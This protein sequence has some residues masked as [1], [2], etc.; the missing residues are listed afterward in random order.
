M[1]DVLTQ[2]LD[3]RLADPDGSG[4]LAVPVRRVAIGRGLAAQAAALLAPLELGPRLAVVHDPDTRLAMGDAVLAA[5]RSALGDASVVDVTLERAPH[6]D[7]ATVDVVIAR[8]TG[9][10]ALVAVG[11]G[12]VNDLVKHAA[13]RTGRPW[14][15]FGTA[16]SM[17]GYTSVSAAITEHGHKKSLPAV[18]ARG[19][20]L[21]LDVLAAAPRHMIAAGL[22]DSICRPTAQF[23]WWLSHRLLDTPYRRVPFDLLA[24]D[25]D[26]LLDSAAGLVRGDIAAL[27]RL[28][29][30]LVLS[31]LGMTL[32]GGSWPASQGEH[33]VSHLLEMRP[34]PT[35]PPALH[36][37][38]IAVTT[39]TLARLQAA[40]VAQAAP[41]F[42]PPVLSRE[43][44]HARF[45]ADLGASCWVASAAKRF[46]AAQVAAIDTRLRAVWPE[47]RTQLGAMSR[48]VEQI[49]AA[50]AAA[51]A[52][53]T[54]ARLGIAETDYAAAVRDA[55]LIRDRFTV[56]DVLAD[57]S[58]AW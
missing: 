57:A 37:E 15:V 41:R 11:S 48:P 1:S 5:L 25:E 33:L 8:S 32:V 3:G 10:D 29:R 26:A 24:H 19:V 51:G 12:T 9:A 46:D 18:A 43:D 38:Q 58:G 16:P 45:G 7:T 23:D 54:P 42:A 21:D 6:P 53:R 47:L 4:V 14:V 56:L 27:E 50:L 22:G 44:Y 52:P 39:L 49:D 31:G 20:F 17:N 34:D 30:T 13:F 2:L 40:F 28:A 36:G 35:W 55:R